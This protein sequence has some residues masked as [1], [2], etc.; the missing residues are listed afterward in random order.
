[1]E[2]LAYPPGSPSPSSAN[3]DHGEGSSNDTSKSRSPGLGGDKGKSPDTGRNSNHRVL[4]KLSIPAE[5]NGWRRIVR[6]FTPSWF[7]V[8]M[9]TGIVSILLHKMPYNSQWLYWPS[10]ILFAFNIIIFVL[11]LAIS[12]L[13]YSL[14]PEI[15]AVMIR[16]QTQSLF[17][18]AFPMALATIVNMVVFVCV[19]A[20]G[21]NAITLAYVLWW[22]DAVISVVVCFYLPFVIM[23]KHSGELSTMTAAWLLPVVPTIVAAA[24]G[25]IVAEV[26]KSD[27]QVLWTVLSSYVL[28]GTG[29]PLAMAILV[30]YF[31]R[32]TIHKLPPREVIVSVFLPLGPLGQGGFA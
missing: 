1:M 8:S 27:D 18:G 31:H 2:P 16:H 23:H 21:D 4:A 12:I 13:R 11:A 5:Y 19:P 25:G 7:A 20:W 14:Y 26:L 6:S 3:L 22:I 28:W 32:L 10:V 9:G 30:I 15:W 24:S 17:I 29:V